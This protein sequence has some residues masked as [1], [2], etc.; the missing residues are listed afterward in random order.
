MR[1]SS[2]MRRGSLPE[3]EFRGRQPSQGEYW[4]G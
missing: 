1:A 2:S 4:E 3:I